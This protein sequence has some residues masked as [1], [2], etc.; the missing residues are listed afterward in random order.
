M[1]LANRMGIFEMLLLGRNGV[2]L[3]EHIE[4]DGQINFEHACRM[5]GRDC[6]EAPRSAVPERAS[7][8]LDQSQKS[9]EPCGPADYGRRGVVAASA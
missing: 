5:L 7:E 2:R 1:S 9:C 6:V 3:L 8:K 4:G